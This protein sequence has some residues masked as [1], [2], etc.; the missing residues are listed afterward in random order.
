[1]YIV[2]NLPVVRR[3]AR[4]LS[5]PMVIVETLIDIVSYSI[6][7]CILTKVLQPTLY[8]SRGFISYPSSRWRDKPVPSSGMLQAESIKIRYCDGDVHFLF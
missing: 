2:V 3:R 5:V 6:R 1:M 7:E 8:Q 4:R